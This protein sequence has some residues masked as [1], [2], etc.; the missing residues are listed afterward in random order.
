[1]RD[2]FID[3][4]RIL[5][6]PGLLLLLS[7]IATADDVSNP[8]GGGWRQTTGI[9]FNPISEELDAY[10]DNFRLLDQ[11]G[12]A[13]TMIQYAD[14]ELVVLIGYRPDCAHNSTLLESIRELQR[15]FDPRGIQFLLLNPSLGGRREPITSE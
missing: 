14:H 13:H 8:V 2:L 12:H 1:M 5:A 6:V 9:Y 11:R 4:C 7:G 3:T 15:R 10:M